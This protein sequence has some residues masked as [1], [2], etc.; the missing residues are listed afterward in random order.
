MKSM[1]N[2]RSLDE[3]APAIWHPA[4]CLNDLS[5]SERFVRNGLGMDLPA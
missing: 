4:H 2:K 1:S 5:G 3:T